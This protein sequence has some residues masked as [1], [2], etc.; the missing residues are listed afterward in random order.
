MG[1]GSSCSLN[2][3]GAG[4]RYDSAR[5]HADRINLER[6]NM[7]YSE[8]MPTISSDDTTLIFL[9]SRPGGFGGGDLWFCTRTKL[10]GER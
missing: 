6:V 4:A 1:F 2:L 10:R 7:V 5:A 3:N 9:S 8:Q